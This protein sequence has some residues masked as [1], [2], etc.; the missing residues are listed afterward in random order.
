[1]VKIFTMVKGEDDIVKDWVLYHGYL[2]GFENLY[3]IDNLSRDNTF[4]IL[5]ELKK[6]YNINV[7]R[8]GDYKKKGIYMTALFKKFCRNEFGIPLDIDEFLVYYNKDT[9]KIIC[10]KEVILNTLRQ[11]PK[12]QVYKMEYIQ[13][14]LTKKDGYK[15][16]LIESECGSYTPYKSMAKSFFHSDLFSGVIDHGNHYNTNNYLLTPFCLVHFH[17]RNLDQIKKKVFNNVSGLGYNPFNLNR[18]RVIAGNTANSGY[19]HA[20]KQVEL[21]T[22]TYK[23]PYDECNENDISLKP[24]NEFFIDK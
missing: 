23:L 4:P 19:H 18:L 13:S 9:N 5:I 22:N 8:I 12:A 20:I 3:I 21:L 6:Q 10:S 7:Y 24:L 11:L 17:N 16:A 1:M 2:F 15:R 14:K